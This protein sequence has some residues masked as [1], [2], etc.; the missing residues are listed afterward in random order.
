MDEWLLLQT[1]FVVYLS[2]F[3]LLLGGAFGLPMPEDIPLILAGILAHRGS[4]SL[5]IAFVVCYVAIVLGDLIIFQIGRRFGPKVFKSKLF[6][7]KL[8]PS[9]IRRLKINLERRSL[10]MI[11]V[12]RHLFY[13]RSVTFLTC[14]AVKMHPR[15]FILAD[16]LAALISV[17]IMIGLGYFF[18]EQYDR[19]VGYVD[20]AKEASLLIAFLGVIVVYLLYRKRKKT[21]VANTE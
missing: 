7:K 15:R 6:Q 18:S 8:P 21:V 3:L 20:K 9:K 12:A 5:K 17:P 19:V 10:M 2:L 16:S 1:G 14:G 13:L 11:F 4:I